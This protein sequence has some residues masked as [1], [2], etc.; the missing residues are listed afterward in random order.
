MEKKPEQFMARLTS[1][2]EGLLVQ[3]RE[4]FYSGDSGA[5]PLAKL[6]ASSFQYYGNA[7]ARM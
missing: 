1:A 4:A 5:V 2:R 6:A 7:R 3:W